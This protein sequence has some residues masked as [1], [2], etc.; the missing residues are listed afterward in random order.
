MVLSGAEMKS[1]QSSSVLGQGLINSG[2]KTGSTNK[3]WG[4]NCKLQHGT[5]FCVFNTFVSSTKWEKDK[6]LGL[7][8]VQYAWHI[9]GK[10]IRRI[11]TPGYL[12]SPHEGEHRQTGQY[13][14]CSPRETAS[15]KPWGK[16]KFCQLEAPLKGE[17][18]IR[19]IEKRSTIS[20][21]GTASPKP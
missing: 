18:A 17:D 1:S 3:H 13:T 15:P 8:V 7:E 11:S 20:P 6:V 5:D 2:D 14:P 21:R 19:P 16:R 12:R 9:P 10:Y 4:Q